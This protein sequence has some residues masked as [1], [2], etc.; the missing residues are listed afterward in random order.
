MANFDFGLGPRASARGPPRARSGQVAMWWNAS[1]IATRSKR[2]SQGSRSACAR[3]AGGPSPRPGQHPGRGV[4]HDRE[5]ATCRAARGEANR[6]RPE[7]EQAG[8]RQ[9]LEGLEQVRQ[10]I[11]PREPIINGGRGHRICRSGDAAPAHSS[12]RGPLERPERK[13][14]NNRHTGQAAKRSMDD[15]PLEC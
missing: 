4:G 12:E 10:P 5:G 3:T 11:T 8:L 2:R 7:V 14:N 13:P 15:R 6:S 9:Q 1:T